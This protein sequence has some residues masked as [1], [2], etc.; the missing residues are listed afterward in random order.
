MPWS[1]IRKWKCGELT[2]FE[3]DG[4][5]AARVI[6]GIPGRERFAYFVFDLET[7]KSLG[8]GP[9]KSILDG[10]RKVEEYWAREAT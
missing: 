2:E 4:K 3:L 6:S 5:I 7:F 10:I 1:P 9:C 8:V